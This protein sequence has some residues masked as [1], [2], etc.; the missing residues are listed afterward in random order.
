MN[1]INLNCKTAVTFIL[2][3]CLTTFAL[4]DDQ[5]IKANAV[6]TSMDEVPTALLNTFKDKQLILLGE[7][8]GTN[9]MPAYA[10]KIIEALAQ[11][12][13]I[14]VG[15]EYP[16]DIQ[17]QID[18]FMQ[19][20]DASQLKETI[21]FQEPDF[22]S[23]RGSQAMLKFLDSLR[24]FSNVNVFCFD[25]PLNY[26]GKTRDTDMALNIMA[27]LESE[28]YPKAVLYSGNIHSRLSVGTPWN[29]TAQNM[30][31]E[32]LRLSNG[33]YNLN[34]VDNLIFR[35]NEGSSWSCMQDGT[36]QFKCTTQI[37]QPSNTKYATAVSLDYYFLQEPALTE[38]H[39]NSFF[40]R[41]V[42]ASDPF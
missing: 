14:L 9:E 29:P 3:F 40:I 10:G 17:K 28:K 35:A 8:H 16:V 13:K 15:I 30:G 18:V 1:H 33:R 22:H 20:G 31:A 6:A 37:W 27:K 5:Y 42:S 19:T 39:K 21:F 34:N 2:F 26:K 24:K 36:G 11:N 12:Q 25:I 23:G 38:G 7:F 41:K 4:T 32:I